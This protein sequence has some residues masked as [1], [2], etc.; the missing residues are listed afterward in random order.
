MLLK[1]NWLKSRKKEAVINPE[2]Q[3]SN[4][5][6]HR[7]NETMDIARAKA[8]LSILEEKYERYIKKIEQYQQRASE[9]KSAIESKKA[10]LK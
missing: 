2:L 4:K 5:S 7:R 3:K 10:K 6:Y 9:I 8:E 1:M